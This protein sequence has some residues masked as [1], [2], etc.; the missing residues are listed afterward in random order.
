[1]SP[2]ASVWQNETFLL[3]IQQTKGFN[4]IEIVL[5][6]QNFLLISFSLRNEKRLLKLK[7]QQP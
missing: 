7:E 5:S 4:E 6:E 3:K 2:P 1:M